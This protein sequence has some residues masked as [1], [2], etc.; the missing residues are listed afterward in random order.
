[1]LVL[2]GLFLLAQKGMCND[3]GIMST[4]TRGAQAQVVSSSATV[5][6]SVITQPFILVS[7]Q[8]YNWTISPLRASTWVSFLKHGRLL[9]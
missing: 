5:G 9:T 7:N 3:F 4:C 1:M 2:A 6:I 8:M